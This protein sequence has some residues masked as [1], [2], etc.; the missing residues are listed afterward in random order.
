M[1]SLLFAIW[2]VMDLVDFKSLFSEGKLSWTDF[3]ES[4]RIILLLTLLQEQ[5][6]VL[7]HLSVLGF[8]SPSQP[9]SVS[10]CCYS[11]TIHVSLHVA[12]HV[13]LTSK[14]Q[15]ASHLVLSYFLHCLRQILSHCILQTY[16]LPWYTSCYFLRQC[17]TS[18]SLMEH[19][20]TSFKPHSPR[21]TV[22]H[23]I[24][25][26]WQTFKWF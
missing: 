7:S 5:F 10:C 12:N 17:I 26:S 8:I 3:R 18:I 4:G 22:L 23:E 20:I 25:P 14:S 21:R 13:I 9:L 24:L 11:V 19:S 6:P 15:S 2:D 16:V 1:T